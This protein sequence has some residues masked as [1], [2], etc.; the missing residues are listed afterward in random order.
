MGDVRLQIRAGSPLNDLVELPNRKE[1]LSRCDRDGTG[2]RDGYQ[3]IDRADLARF[4]DEQRIIR[5]DPL[6]VLDRKLETRTAM[7][8][9]H[10]RR[11][12]PGRGAGCCNALAAEIDRGHIHRVPA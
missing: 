2:L 11:V 6:C 5:R 8:I 4:L 12:V 7:G 10:D 1:L 3:G 9:E